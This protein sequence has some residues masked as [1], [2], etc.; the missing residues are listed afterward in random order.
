[1]KS[2]PHDLPC[3]TISA[4][5]YED[6]TDSNSGGHRELGR[7]GLSFRECLTKFKQG[8]HHARGK[9]LVGRPSCWD[10]AIRESGKI[11]VADVGKRVRTCLRPSNLQW[12][13]GT[14]RLGGLR[15]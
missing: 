8:P 15:K 3:S 12:A 2:S 6:H 7:M 4:F 14:D 10:T 9:R 11:G 13:P 5:L 1:M